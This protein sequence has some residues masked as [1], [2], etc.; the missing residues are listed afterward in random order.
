[1]STTTADGKTIPSG[2]EKAESSMN[3]LRNVSELAGR[4]LLAALFLVSGFGED[5]WLRGDGGLHGRRWACRAPCS[6]W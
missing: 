3:G 5:R 1:M 2:S 4:V 6:P